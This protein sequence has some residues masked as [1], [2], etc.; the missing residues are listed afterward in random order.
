MVESLTA[1]PDTVLFIFIATVVCVPLLGLFWMLARTREEELR[2]VRELSQAGHR[3]DEIAM[4][5]KRPG[6]D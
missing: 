1:H 6:K 3:P 5:V 2:T 4:L